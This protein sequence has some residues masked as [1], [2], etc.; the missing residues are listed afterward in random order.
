MPLSTENPRNK[1]KSADNSFKLNSF[2][3]FRWTVNELVKRN[4]TVKNF[5]NTLLFGKVGS[6]RTL[7]FSMEIAKKNI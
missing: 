1:F 2:N 5:A 4:A 7:A 3:N 6:S